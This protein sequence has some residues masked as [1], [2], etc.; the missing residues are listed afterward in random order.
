MSTTSLKGGCGPSKIATEAMCM[1]ETSSSMCRNEASKGL[2]RS[3]LMQPPFHAPSADEVTTALSGPWG[4]VA[5][6]GRGGEG[7]GLAERGQ[8]GRLEDATTRLLV[9]GL[10]DPGA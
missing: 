6:A 10:D 3:G 2:N 9:G 1:W 5:S 4:P 7:A 8:E